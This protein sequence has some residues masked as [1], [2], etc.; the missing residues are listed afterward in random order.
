MNIDHS[1]LGQ[2]RVITLGKILRVSTASIL[3]SLCQDSQF[4]RCFKV[5]PNVCWHYPP[6][7]SQHTS[8][9]MCQGGG[10]RLLNCL[11]WRINQLI[12]KMNTINKF[13]TLFLSTLTYFKINYTYILFCCHINF[14]T[15]VFG[16]GC[17]WER[18]F[19]TLWPA[20]YSTE[21][22][23]NTDL[24]SQSERE[25]ERWTC[26]RART[27]PCRLEKIVR[28]NFWEQ[29]FFFFGQRERERDER[30]CERGARVSKP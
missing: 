13:C 4:L 6:R 2:G 24:Q 18:S 29:F 20:L 10:E 3:P 12:L 15:G 9:L 23:H 19:I 8:S 26:M 21:S 17:G 27:R 7:E 28:K 25:R 1:D 14:K 5:R 16:W 30:A 22:L 11:I